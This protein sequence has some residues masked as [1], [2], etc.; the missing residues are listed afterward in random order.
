MQITKKYLV[1]AV[2]LMMVPFPAISENKDKPQEPGQKINK[3]K[4]K[5]EYLL[6]YYR[7]CVINRLII[8]IAHAT[9]IRN[10]SCPCCSNV[11]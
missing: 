9:Q 2:A 6:P 5:Y 11:Q 3:N 10:P 7:L 4:G 1:L 8:F